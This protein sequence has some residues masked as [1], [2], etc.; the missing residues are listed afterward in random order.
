MKLD[1]DARYMRT[2]QDLRMLATGGQQP[3][4]SIREELV[5]PEERRGQDDN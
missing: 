5:W 2:I 3:S 4:G 1:L